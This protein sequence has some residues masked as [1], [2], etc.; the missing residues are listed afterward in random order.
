M[1]SYFETRTRIIALVAVGASLATLLLRVVGAPGVPVFVASAIGLAGLAAMVGEGTE[2][3][4]R[5]LGPNATGVLQSALGNLPEFFIGIFA[6]RAGLLDVV[7]A[8]LVGSI[9]ANALL[10]LGL[11]FVAGGLR[12]GPQKFGT[13]Q[14]KM[15]STLLVLAA[16]SIA[17]PTIAASPGGPA[18]G[19]ET[20]LSVVVSIVLLVVFAASLP[21]S[22]GKGPAVGSLEGASKYENSWPVGLATATLI[23]AGLGA[24]FVSDWFVEALT[25]A[26]DSLGMS[27]AFAGLVVVAIA[28]NAVENFVGI[29]AML[30]DKGDLAVS[31]ILNSSL[32]V[33][34]VLAPVLV[35]ASLVMGGATLT[36]VVSPLLVAALALTALLAALVVI[37]GESTW[38]EGLALIGLYVILAASVWWGQP[39]G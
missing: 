11:A 36:L 3:L 27:Q 17:I 39:I 10:V 29:S 21:F 26:M 25:P 4:G 37:D 23:A 18:Y 31:V 15:I 8:A 24:A 12:H 34:L 1:L 20:E 2:Q 28:G 35:L 14:T 9:L 19:H 7:R 13:D 22:I 38:I 33:A 6:L 32:Q 30:A 5:R 16:A